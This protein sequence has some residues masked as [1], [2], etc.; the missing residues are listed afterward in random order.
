MKNIFKGH[1]QDGSNWVVNNEEEYKELLAL[2]KHFRR[3]ILF[4]EEYNPKFNSITIWRDGIARGIYN[5]EC[6][7]NYPITYDYYHPFYEELV[8]ANRKQKIIS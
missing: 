2:L 8:D 3:K 1:M 6:L 7:G 5:P 4:D